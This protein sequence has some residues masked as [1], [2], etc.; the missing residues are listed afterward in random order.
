LKRILNVLNRSFFKSVTAVQEE[1]EVTQPQTFETK[2]NQPK[3]LKKI[4]VPKF[5]VIIKKNLGKLII[6]LDK[7]IKHIL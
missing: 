5:L 1:T 6:P 2:E 3:I 4:V 7:I